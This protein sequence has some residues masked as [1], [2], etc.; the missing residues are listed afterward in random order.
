MYTA[1]TPQDRLL[2]EIRIGLCVTKSFAVFCAISFITSVS[3]VTPQLML[4]LVGDLAP[5]HR[6]AAALSIVVSGLL[7]GMLIA[8]V[9]SGVVTQFIG[10]RYVYWISFSL[11]YLILVLLYFFLPDYASTNPDQPIL[12]K[13]P[14]L[15]LD[16]VKLLF[17]HPV[18]VQSCLIGFFT[19]STFTSYWT[20]LTFLL[21]GDPYHYTPLVTGLFALIAIA[22]MTWGPIFA[23]LVMDKHEP[24]F[25]IIVGELFCLVGI[26][27]GTYTGLH[28]VAGPV[29]QALFIDIGVQTSQIANRTAI[30]SVAPKARNRVNTAYMTC[31]F[32]GQLMGTAAGNHLYAKGGWTSSGSAS[33]AFICSALVLCLVRGPHE[34]GWI[35]WHGSYNMKKQHT[36][37]EGATKEEEKA[38][39]SEEKPQPFVQGGNHKG[40]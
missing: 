9:L 18:L 25:S 20:T 7:L 24:L 17:K 22:S 6:R 14:S 12:R 10:W 36:M 11:Q 2:I 8:R 21:A 33:V 15:L 19:S 34:K 40:P 4:P 39:Q 37:P 29:V 32:T 27:V 31:V 35:G 30:Y 28:T 16:I 3:T 23:R 38:S 26:V 5:P 1:R 13:Y